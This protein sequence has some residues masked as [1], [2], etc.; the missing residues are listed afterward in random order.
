MRCPQTAV[1][2]SA[3]QASGTPYLGQE[4]LVPALESDLCRHICRILSYSSLLFHM[5]LYTQN[6][7]TVDEAYVTGQKV[8]GRANQRLGKLLSGSPEDLRF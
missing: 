8:M 2:P 4:D 1:S 5:F 6:Q 7:A 3:L